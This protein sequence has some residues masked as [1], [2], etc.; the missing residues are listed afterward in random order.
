M[1]KAEVALSHTCCASSV[2]KHV[3][4]R[5]SNPSPSFLFSVAGP[6]VSMLSSHPGSIEFILEV[7]TLAMHTHHTCHSRL[8]R[9]T[10]GKSNQI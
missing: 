9:W 5:L 10:N 4:R 7:L 6:P 2:R 8:H 1:Y 3:T